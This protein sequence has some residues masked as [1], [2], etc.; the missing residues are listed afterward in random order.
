M[1]SFAQL[2]NFFCQKIN[3]NYDKI[4]IYKLKNL[5]KIY[6]EHF[7]NFESKFLEMF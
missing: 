4:E 5:T 1:Q 2:C 3:K 6:S 7:R